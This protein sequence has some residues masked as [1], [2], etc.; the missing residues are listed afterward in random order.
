LSR[1]AIWWRGGGDPAF[2]CEPAD[3]REITLAGETEITLNQG[4]ASVHAQ[5]RL[6]SAFEGQADVSLTIGDVCK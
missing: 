6:T 4:P 2:N 1:Q 3:G 5:L